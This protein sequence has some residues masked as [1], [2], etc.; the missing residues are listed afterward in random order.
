MQDTQNSYIS[1]E[2]TREHE[3][4]EAREKAEYAR[5]VGAVETLAR[6]KDGLHFL[7]W[8]LEKSNFLGG[9]PVLPHESMAFL[10]GQRSVGHAL[11]DLVKRARCIEAVCAEEDDLNG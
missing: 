3:E 8:L 4:R 10:E 1:W 9:V 2:S 5:L 6:T 7:H 11:F